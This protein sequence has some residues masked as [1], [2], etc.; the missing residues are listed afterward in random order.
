[1]KRNQMRNPR[2]HHNVV[3]TLK[4]VGGRGNGFAYASSDLG[5]VSG[6]CRGIGGSGLDDSANLGNGKPHC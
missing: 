3:L 4:I 5:A 6:L 2:V 1:M